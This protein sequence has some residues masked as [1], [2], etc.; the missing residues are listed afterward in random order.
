MAI[1]I[2]MSKREIRLSVEQVEALLRVHG[3]RTGPTEEPILKD[4]ETVDSIH[5]EPGE[6]VIWVS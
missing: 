1:K 6:L 4:G 5:T 2:K 3:L